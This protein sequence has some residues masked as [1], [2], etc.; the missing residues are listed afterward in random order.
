[1]KAVLQRRADVSTLLLSEL[2]CPQSSSSIESLSD[3]PRSGHL[4]TLVQFERGP[5]AGSRY[6]MTGCGDPGRRVVKLLRG[7]GRMEAMLLNVT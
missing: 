6:R 1:M 4:A 2:L 5:T 7:G 3:S